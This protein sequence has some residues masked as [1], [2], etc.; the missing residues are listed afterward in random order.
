MNTCRKLQP[1]EPG[2]KKL[3][4]RYGEN[5]ICVRYR[6][7]F[8]GQRR[9]KT[10]ELVVEEVPW[11]PPVEEVSPTQVM[12]VWIPYDDREL[13]KQMEAGSGKWNQ[14]QQA[15]ELPYREVVELGLTD[16]ILE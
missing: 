4:A 9:L 12:R 2:T 1:G 8:A 15:W 6:Y 3:V 11:Q 13:Q 5:L 10:V 7:D 14:Q 16:F